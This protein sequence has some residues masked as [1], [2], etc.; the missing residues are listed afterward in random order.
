MSRAP[1]REWCSAG[2]R[3]L[4]DESVDAVTVDRLCAALKKTRRAALLQS[5]A[6]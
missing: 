1:P 3:L 2:L 6:G 4:R 5:V